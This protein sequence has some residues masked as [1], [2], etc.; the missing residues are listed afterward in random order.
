MKIQLM[1]T[2]QVLRPAKKFQTLRKPNHG[3]VEKGKYVYGRGGR[4]VELRLF[5]GP[6][7]GA[8]WLRLVNWSAIPPLVR[9]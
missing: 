9:R 8:D 2:S 7:T 4:L 5:T 6:T 3:P 1:Q